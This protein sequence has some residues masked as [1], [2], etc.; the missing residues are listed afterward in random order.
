MLYL[1]FPFKRCTHCDGW[2]LPTER[3][4]LPHKHTK[5]RLNSWCRAC[6]RERTRQ[7]RAENPEHVRALERSY[8]QK[9]L[10]RY[11]E[12]HREYRR[13]HPESARQSEHRWREAHPEQKRAS[14]RRWYHANPEKAKAQKRRTYLAHKVEDNARS[15][16]WSRTHPQAV[17]EK[18][19]RYRQTHPDKVLALYRNRRARK[20]GLAHGF[21]ASDW[22]KALDYFH[23]CCAYC[24]EPPGF[25]SHLAQ[26]HFLP[27][28]RGGGYTKDNIVPACHGIGGCNNHKSDSDPRKWL[29]KRFGKRKAKAILKQIQDYFEWV[30]NQ[31]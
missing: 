9:N 22:Q 4:F 21:T 1:P 18:T 19:R 29:A 14:R 30:N 27:E 25:W 7:W 11:R 31:P 13:R 26:D 6:C 8:Y 23:G 5:D 24:G 17:Y 15:Q 3:Y 10:E 12:Y 16:Q 28:S 20:R 2:F